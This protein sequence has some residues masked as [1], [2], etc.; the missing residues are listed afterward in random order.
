VANSGSRHRKNIGS[1]ASIISGRSR[2]LR[3]CVTRAQHQACAWWCIIEGAA[4]PAPTRL[5]RKTLDNISHSAPPRFRFA[6]P[7][8][9]LGALFPLFHGMGGR[10]HCL[11][12]GIMRA[13]RRLARARYS[14]CAFTRP[15]SIFCTRAGSFRISC[16][17]AACHCHR[18]AALSARHLHLRCAHISSAGCTPAAPF[19]IGFLWFSPPAHQAM[20]RVLHLSGAFSGHKHRAHNSAAFAKPQSS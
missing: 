14:P 6:S 7:P 5:R 13:A 2:W 1:I 11:L 18:T 4:L 9:H 16:A 20:D 17:A 12:R 3:G 8:A 10:R 19:S 15:A